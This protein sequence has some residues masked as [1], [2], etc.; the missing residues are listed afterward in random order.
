MKMLE[1]MENIAEVARDRESCFS[2]PDVKP[3]PSPLITLEMR[4]SAIMAFRF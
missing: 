3:L 4:Q 2:F 1:K